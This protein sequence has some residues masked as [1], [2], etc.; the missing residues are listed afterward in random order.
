MYIDKIVIDILSIGPQPTTEQWE[1]N[2]EE[3]AVVFRK[4][5]IKR[6]KVF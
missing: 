6:D 2:S 3:A 4:K 1:T 5:L